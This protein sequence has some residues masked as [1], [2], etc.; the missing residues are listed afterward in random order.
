MQAPSRLLLKP[1]AYGFLRIGEK[2]PNPV[3]H[4]WTAQVSV[5]AMGRRS[6]GENWVFEMGWVL[7]RNPPEEFLSGRNFLLALYFASV[8]RIAVGIDLSDLA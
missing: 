1:S 5:F 7:T 2:L 4:T 6:A 3:L 8:H